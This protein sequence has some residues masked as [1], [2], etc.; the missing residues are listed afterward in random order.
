MCRFVPVRDPDLPAEAEP[1]HV[2]KVC[3]GTGDKPM[4]QLCEASLTY[5]GLT[6]AGEPADPHNGDGERTL[7]EPEKPI[8]YE[9]DSK[10]AGWYSKP[11]NPEACVLCLKPSIMRS[12]KHV[13]CHKDCAERYNAGERTFARP[14]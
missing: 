6:D 3:D 10:A 14:R 7:T 11:W 8:H 13:P 9:I 12:P 1:T 5:W 2:T 4:C